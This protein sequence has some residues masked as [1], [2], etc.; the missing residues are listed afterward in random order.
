MSLNAKYSPEEIIAKLQAHPKFGSSIMPVTSYQSAIISSELE[1]AVVIA[2][3]GSGKTET[4]SNR[5]LF[6][7][8]YFRLN[9]KK[10]SANVQRIIHDLDQFQNHF[11]FQHHPS[12]S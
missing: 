3:A 7:V 9:N 4:M 8:K 11:I 1:P 10:T 12:W 6:L 2:G 5:V